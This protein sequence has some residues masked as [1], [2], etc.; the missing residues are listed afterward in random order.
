MNDVITCPACGA[1]W[2]PEMRFCGSCGSPLEGSGRE[3]EERK[4]VTVLFADL[5]ASTALA[6]RLD[7]EDLRRILEPFF[8]AMTE[9]VER[10]GGTVQKY[11]GD[12]I[13]AVFGVPAA[14]EDDPGR[15]VP[16][17]LAMHRRLQ[18]LNLELTGR[19]G[20]GP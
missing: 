17:G 11:I 10:F 1:T 7:P 4:V 13:V 19:A 9:E 20:E 2:P 8:L 5:A 16:A 3:L 12:A 18:R 6:S 14:A 15:A